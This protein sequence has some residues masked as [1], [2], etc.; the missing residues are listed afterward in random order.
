MKRRIVLQRLAAPDD[1]EAGA[2]AD[3]QFEHRE[4]AGLLRDRAI[5]LIV[6]HRRDW[7]RLQKIVIPD[8]QQHQSGD[9][10]ALGIHPIGQP[11]PAEHRAIERETDQHRQGQHGRRHEAHRRAI[12]IAQQPMQQRIGQIDARAADLDVRPQRQNETPH[13]QRSTRTSARHRGE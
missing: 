2:H 11:L 5:G 1:S 12:L 8:E 7:K 9:E 3:R 13:G 4:I 6:G 10:D